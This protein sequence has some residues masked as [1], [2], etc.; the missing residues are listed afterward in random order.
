MNIIEDKNLQFQS[1]CDHHGWIE[2]FGKA[3][4]K[5]ISLNIKEWKH[6]D[7]Q[8]GNRKHFKLV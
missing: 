2:V 1:K 7:R 3:L 6:L 8:R 5:G 4:C